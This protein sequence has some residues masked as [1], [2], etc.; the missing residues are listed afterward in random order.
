MIDLERLSTVDNEDPTTWP[1]LKTGEIWVP[2]FHL[3]ADYPTPHD[4][5]MRELWTEHMGVNEAVSTNKVFGV[6][7]PPAMS[8][9]AVASVDLCEVIRETQM[10]LFDAT[11]VTGNHNSNYSC[12][13]WYDPERVGES[14][15]RSIVVSVAR[16][17][18]DKGLV[19]PVDEIEKITD[20]LA[21]WRKAGIWV[22]ANTSTL[23]GC[24]PG[25]IKHTLA[26]STSSQFDGI[27]FPRNHDGNGTVTKATALKT[28]I[29]EAGVS[30]DVPIIH[31]D[32][33]YYHHASFRAE[34]S[35]FNGQMF[36][37]AP[38]Y[39]GKKVAHVDFEFS[40]PLE[41]FV[42]A[43]ALFNYLGVTK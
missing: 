16:V 4:E 13:T 33:A 17:L 8:V 41:T 37:L 24:E 26:K 30:P 7:T 20:I 11:G 43:N 5:Q 1:Q 35:S 6:F 15:E 39:D 25:T 2:G 3:D 36:L 9:K 32:D 23:P 31:I 19:K 42:G 27:V 34:K 38:A 18:I 12:G 40:S 14:K 29:D 10:S 21:G 22:I 28:I